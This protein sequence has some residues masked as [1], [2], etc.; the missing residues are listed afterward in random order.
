MY[1]FPLWFCKNKPSVL[2]LVFYNSLRELVF[3]VKLSLVA[4]AKE[5]LKDFFFCF[6]EMLCYIMEEQSE[7]YNASL[8]W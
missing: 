3:H 6:I 5:L 8:P 4:L 7:N 1:C 2:L